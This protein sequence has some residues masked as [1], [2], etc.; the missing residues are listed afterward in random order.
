MIRTQHEQAQRDEYRAYALRVRYRT[1]TDELLAMC[2]TS[3]GADDEV[4][5]ELDRRDEFAERM[6]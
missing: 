6:R 1:S 3:P 2:N 5:A 4:L